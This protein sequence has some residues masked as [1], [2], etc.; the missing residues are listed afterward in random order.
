MS[1][2]I[3][4]ATM[5]SYASGGATAT[6]A[7]STE[8]HL[9]GCAHCRARLVPAVDPGRLNGIWAEVEERVDVV[10]L[11]IVERILV[12]CGMRDDTAR[13]LAATPSL[14]ASW[15][16]AVGAAV[17][18]AVAAADASPRGLAVFLTLA[19]MLPVAGVAAAYGRE[20]DP[21]YELAVASPYSLLR[22]LLVRSV[23][24]VGTTLVL[25]AVGGLLLSGAG[26]RS[27][28]WLLPA[29]ALS[30]V[31]LALSA[32][33]APVWA[34]GGVLIGWLSI[35]LTAWQITGNRLAAF[36]DAGQVIAVTVTALA[37][38]VLV[39]NR[40]DFAYDT[41]RSA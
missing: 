26:W 33:V 7:A 14:T 24:V 30:A 18:F 23:A 11:P 36:G 28:G 1:W 6:V 25:T 20:A 8:A 41:R 32:R 40:S 38:T 17:V 39:A 19:P 4:E 9:T 31:T 29:L 21:A 3:D 37:L 13:L 34:G 22:L 16:A 27:A 5:A 15:L 35:V 12:R 2:H 10:S